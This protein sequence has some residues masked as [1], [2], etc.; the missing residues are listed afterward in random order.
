MLLAGAALIF[1]CKQKEEIAYYMTADKTAISDIAANNPSDETLV[2]KTNSPTWLV[3]TPDWITAT[4]N[5]GEGSEDGTVITFKIA[6]NYKNESTDTAPRNGSVKF[7]GSGQTLEVPISQNGHTAV[8]DPNASIG[9]ITDVA[10]F[11]DFVKAVNSGDAITRWLNSD[12]EVELLDDIDLGA[13]SEWTPIGYVTKSGNGNNASNPEGPV[14]TGTFN[15]G[16]HTIKN[17]KASALIPDGKT[18]GLFG[19]TKNAVIKNLNIVADV[20]LE[21]DAVADAG[22]LVGTAYST[23]IENVK[24]NGKLN[25]KGTKTDN[26]RFAIG[27]IAGF[28][29]SIATEGV[30]YNTTIKNCE[31]TLE[32]SGNSGAN[33]KNGATCVHFG[34]I[35]GF[36]TN[37]KDDARNYIE[38]C[39]FNG[40]MKI[41]CGRCAGIAG[42]S[43]FGTIIK[44]CVNNASMHNEFTNGREAG[45]VCVIAEQCAIIDCINNGNLTTIDTGTTLGGFFALLNHASCYIEGGANYGDIICANE[46]YRG[47]IGANFSKF[48]HVSGVK[49]GGR[50]G[51][52]EASL[53]AATAANY[54]ELIGFVVDGGAEKITNLE[55]ASK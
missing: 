28:L 41:D 51:E 12:G 22:I 4:P 2:L 39:T 21:A 11:E 23:T 46:K 34:G 16:G 31:V 48:D 53:V 27:G 40:S 52:S 19:A 26:K 3:L 9:G 14:F 47:L 17:F 44:G 18:W 54:M 7:S 45:I 29:Y 35:A 50:I 25:I 5:Y 33:T 8:I 43:N 1:S 37:S 6:S 32:A 30:S 36:S 42:V 13:Y 15:G 10:E 38:N 55:F 49:V 24:I 20:T